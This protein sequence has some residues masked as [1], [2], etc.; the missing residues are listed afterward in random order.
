MKTCTKCGVE[1]SLDEYFSRPSA[2]D[3]KMSHCKTCKTASYKAWVDRNRERVNAASN[4]RYRRSE[5]RKQ[6]LS[7]AAERKRISAEKS[8]A[9][10]KA[11]RAEYEKRPHVVAYR[12]AYKA[13]PERIKKTSQL[14]KRPEKL[15]ARAAKM[16]A[17][18]KTDPKVLLNGR[19]TCQMRAKLRGQKAGRSWRSMVDYTVEE[20]RAH[21]ERQFL[22]GMGWHN[23]GEWHIDH[24]IPVSSFNY[25]SPDDL[26][27]KR[28]WALANLRPL[29]GR[30]NIRKSNRV[31]TLL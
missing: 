31:E 28:C 9:R 26:E 4:E 20:L 10:K 24:I 25:T 18:R 3:G 1:K 13:K 5:R 11:F 2:S 23:A 8:A 22:R 30:D 29:W 19:M 7:T 6:R 27:F 15:S 17:L 16:R 12:T 14:R 21:L